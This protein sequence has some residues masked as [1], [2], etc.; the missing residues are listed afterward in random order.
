MSGGGAKLLLPLLLINSAFADSTSDARIQAY[1][2]NRL[3]S[4]EVVLPTTTQAQPTEEVVYFNTSSLYWSADTA[5][6]AALAGLKDKYGD[7]TLQDFNDAFGENYYWESYNVVD[8]VHTPMREYL[9]L[10]A[11]GK[12]TSDEISAEDALAL[13]QSHLDAYSQRGGYCGAF[14]VTGLDFTGKSFWETDL[15]KMKGLTQD[16]LLSCSSISTCNLPQGI[17]LDGTETLP[18]M[19]LVDISTWTG[20]TANQLITMG[21]M[22]NNIK[23]PDGIDFTGAD[24]SGISINGMDLS[25]TKGLTA[26]MF[27]DSGWGTNVILPALAFS[28]NENLGS[29]A[30]NVDYSKCTG[31]NLQQLQG[32]YISNLVLPAMDVS[33]HLDLLT[34]WSIDNCDFTRVTGL[35]GEALGK[36]ENIYGIRLTQD[37]YTEFLP[38]LKQSP[39][40]GVQ[41]Y[42]DGVKVTIP[43]P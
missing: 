37:Q 13:L 24:L 11:Q 39:H 3:L 17:V 1:K 42:V 21:Y 29:H 19:E 20:V 2:A 30:E 23:L 43:A 36:A 28:G 25:N 8:D 35:T 14:P 18:Y 5:E 16:Q 10:I 33:P 12:I 31:M 34:G 15:S 40:V 26:Q 38:A 27:A 41:I 7:W 6:N 4:Q 32:E 22:W 9:S